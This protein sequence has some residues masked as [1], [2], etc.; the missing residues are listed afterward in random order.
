MKQY[1]FIMA[2]ALLTIPLQG[3]AE[4]SFWS[5][6]SLERKKGVKPVDLPL[7]QDEC[8]ACHYAYPPGLLPSKSWKLLLT[9]EALEDHF[10]ENAELDA[11]TINE[12]LAY[13]LPDAAEH[14]NYKRSKKIALSTKPD[15]IPER[16]SETRYIRRKHMKIPDH[17][18]EG[19]DKIKSLAYCD[20]CHTKTD[21]GI[22]DDDSV[23]IKGY[24]AADDV[25]FE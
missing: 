12:L 25:S 10:G 19:N 16:V 5:W 6:F 11:E 7:Y 14:S 18:V 17:M 24:G 9:A 15:E 20:A 3:F 4:S 13:L 2:I 21:E 1:R 22:F 23:Y 8:G